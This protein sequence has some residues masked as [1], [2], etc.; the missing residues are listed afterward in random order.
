MTRSSVLAAA[1]CWTLRSWRRTMWMERSARASRAAVF[2]GPRLP[3]V[4][5]PTTSGTGSE[6]SPYAVVTVDGKKVFYTSENLLPNAA[7]I[8][9]LLTVSMPPRTTAATALD[10]LTHALE[11]AMG[12]PVP[13]TSAI[14]A[15]TLR[16]ILDAR[17]ARW[18]TGRMCRH[19]MICRLPL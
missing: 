13:F 18:K 3:L 19:A 1:A 11:G 16:L 6:V 17:R 7:L 12:R 8:D 10:A 2:S 5:L 4:L 15:E 14:A 9:P